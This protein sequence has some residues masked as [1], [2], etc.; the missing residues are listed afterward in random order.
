MQ[1]FVILNQKG[2]TGKTTVSINLAAILAMH[3]KKV[4]LIDMDPQGN[5][6]SAS[7]IHK[8]HLEHGVYDVLYGDNIE[9]NIVYSLTNEYYILPANQGLAAVEVE[10]AAEGNWHRLLA[11]G[12][13][14]IKQSFDYV[15]IDCPPSLGVLTINALVAA[16]KLLIPMQCEYFA[17]E[18]LSD[19]AQTLHHLNQGWNQSLT[20]GGIIRSVYDSRNRLSQEVSNEL[21]THF[22]D[23]LFSTIICRNVRLAEAPSH[24]KSIFQHSVNSQGATNYREL[25][26]EF[27]Q[28]FG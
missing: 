2:G 13:A 21:K 24:Q 5:A 9:D 3:G 18:G 11:N 8:N 10:L 16:D 26:V 22:G 23:K 27:L 20:I 17:L 4:L 19:L 6:S 25:G 14:G 15:F 12:I 28:R 7:G 1:T